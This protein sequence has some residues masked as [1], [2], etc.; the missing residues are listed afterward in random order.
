MA[1][2]FFFDPPALGADF[3]LEGKAAS[4]AASR[5]SLSAFFFATYHTSVP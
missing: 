2:G 5:A 4:S 1:A 3:G